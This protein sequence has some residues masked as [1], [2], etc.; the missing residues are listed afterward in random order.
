MA[1]NKKKIQYKPEIQVFDA[2]TMQ[3]VGGGVASQLM[4]NAMN[5]QALRPWNENG[6]TYINVDGQVHPIANA[7]TL[8]KDEWKRMDDAILRTSRDR[9]TVVADLLAAGLTYPLE[10]SLAT[11]VLEYENISDMEAAQVS[12]DARTRGDEDR[13]EYDIVYLPIPI[14]FKDFSINIR[15]LE[16]S[17]RV[18]R[19][20]DTTMAEEA[21]RKV[22]EAIE[23]MTVVGT[24][25]PTFGSGTVKGILNGPSINTG[26]MDVYWNGSAATGATMLGDVLNMI[27]AAHSKKHYGPYN[28]YIPTNYGVVVEDDYKA[29]SDRTIK[30][31]IEAITSINRVRISDY[32]TAAN[33]ALVQMTSDVIR[34]VT[35]MVATTVQWDTDGGMTLNFKVMAIMVPQVRADQA[36]NSGI[37]KYT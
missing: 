14:V 10:N 32:M 7:S 37:V 21:G 28:L 17:R 36:G 20:L 35:G 2:N 26:S 31:R 5:P 1:K 13:P 15:T 23:A 25:G 33:I 34:M 12:M 22:N 8:R 27:M 18:G 6:K 19:P 30:E 11:T 29:N 24:K 16:A 4:A 3:A 9:L